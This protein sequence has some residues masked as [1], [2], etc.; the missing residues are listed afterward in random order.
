[1]SPSPG[2]RDG[3]PNVT[4]QTTKQVVTLL[5]WRIME[6]YYR[7]V[8]ELLYELSM[9]G[10]ISQ[11]PRWS[12]M[13]PWGWWAADAEFG[14]QFGELLR[15][16]YICL[17]MI[18]MVENILD[19]GFE[20]V[21]FGIW[22]HHVA[23]IDTW[24]YPCSMNVYDIILVGS[25]SIYGWRMSPCSQL[26]IVIIIVKY[27]SPLVSP[28]FFNLP[29]KHHHFN[30]PNI[31]EMLVPAGLFSMLPE[32]WSKC[33]PSLWGYLAGSNPILSEQNIRKSRDQQIKAKLFFSW[34]K[35]TN[36]AIIKISH[37]FS[38]FN[39]HIHMFPIF[40]PYMFPI[41]LPYFSIVS[42]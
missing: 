29:I 7:E 9:S 36:F 11:E 27:I 14:E 26:H 15:Y 16:I 10:G 25:T 3:N 24:D 2:D 41:F 20:T 19:I 37:T 32:P 42:L 6:L 31:W 5:R 40:F 1:M 23:Y 28:L 13:I 4:W 30:L 12:E 39:L 38:E 17:Y 34:T 33:F 35:A 22:L 8:D 21:F 18:Y